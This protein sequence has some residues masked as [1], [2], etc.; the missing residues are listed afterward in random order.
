MAMVFYL[1]VVSIPVFLS[2]IVGKYMKT[3]NSVKNI[4]SRKPFF[5]PD[6]SAPRLPQ[7]VPPIAAKGTPAISD[8]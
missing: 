2:S 3:G 6:P 4:I 7:I 5:R 1:Q 8:D